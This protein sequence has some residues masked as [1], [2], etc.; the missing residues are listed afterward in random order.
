MADGEQIIS[1]ER[2]VIKSITCVIE[3]GENKILIRQQ[4]VADFYRT[5][6]RDPWLRTALLSSL[7]V[8]MES[9]YKTEALYAPTTAS[10]R[11]DD[12]FGPHP[13]CRTNYTAGRTFSG[14]SVPQ[15]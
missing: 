7:I 14:S 6:T 5:E 4:R 10:N 8:T 12:A 11:D 3:D 15:I 9:G 1:I 2:G 13:K